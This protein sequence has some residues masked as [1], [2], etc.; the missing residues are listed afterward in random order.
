MPAARSASSVAIERTT[1][2]TAPAS[3]APMLLRMLMIENALVQ[4][5]LSTFC[6]LGPA[7]W[8]DFIEI[9]CVPQL[10]ALKTP[11][12]KRT[13]LF[14]RTS[15]L[16]FPDCGDSRWPGDSTLSWG[17]AIDNIPDVGPGYPGPEQPEEPEP[18]PPQPEEPVP[19]PP[20]PE[21]PPLGPE[22]PHLPPPD[23]EPGR[24]PDPLP[25]PGGPGWS[26]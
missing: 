21:I 8:R 2:T 14:P 4:K 16:S 7:R 5:F 13:Y 18:P 11:D 10:I 22:E 25:G 17:N 19:Q 3:T 6:L 9:A 12:T 24:Q 26:E 15:V 23:P 20:R 1:P